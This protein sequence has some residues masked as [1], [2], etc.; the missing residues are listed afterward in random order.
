MAAG[1]TTT[2]LALCGAGQVA[3]VHALAADAIEW[4]Q[5]TTVA[6]R[7]HAH[8]EALAARIGARPS[9]YDDLP[10]GADLVLVSTPPATH[11]LEVV[12]AL[13]G[14]AGVLVEQPLAATLDDADRIVDAAAATGG[15]VGYLA[16]LVF[17]PLV[18]ALRF[19]LPAI[20]P[21]QHLEVRALQARPEGSQAHDPAWGGGALLRSGS[22]VIALALLL[23][24]PHH[25]TE[26]HTRTLEADDPGGVDTYAEIDLRFGAA[27]TARVI[28]SWR[29]AAST[30]DI[31]ASSAFGVVRAELLPQR[32]LE[33]NGQPLAVPEPAAGVVPALDEFGYL[34]QLTSLAGSLRAGAPPILDAAFGRQVLEVVCAAGRSAATGVEE[35]L[36]FTGSRH[37][38]PHQ[39]WH[40]R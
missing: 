9:R 28:A 5:V 16:N 23:A 36:P 39:F 11:A 13:Q 15:R 18:D 8:A 3:A 4:L 7:Q 25:P 34:A 6:S 21:V 22:A 35:R 26:V 33:R 27:V 31:Q 20:G 29:E 14:G 24:A 37:L 2:T 1:G 17:A 12:R 38:T 19:E 10:G 40:L 30:W 32:S